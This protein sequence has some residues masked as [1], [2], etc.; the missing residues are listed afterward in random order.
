MNQFKYCDN[1]ER[2][3]PGCAGMYAYQEN[4]PYEVR[5]DAAWLVGMAI[6]KDLTDRRGVKHELRACEM[7]IQAEIV[8]T[9]GNLA[10]EAYQKHVGEVRG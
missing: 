7:E 5:K 1:C 8:A 6:W 9:I 4:C 3:Y 10:I 2:S